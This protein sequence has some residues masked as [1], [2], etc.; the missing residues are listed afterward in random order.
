MSVFSKVKINLFEK[1][2]LRGFASVCVADSFYVTGIRIIEGKNGFFI[3][4][5]SRKNAEGEYLD[6][7]FPAS[8]PFRD[9]LT[10]AVLDAYDKELV[11]VVKGQCPTVG[12]LPDSN[13]ER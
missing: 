5:P 4:M 11:V 7:C 12:W 1:D 9:E 8:K 3:S 10:G 13:S 2:S 6:I